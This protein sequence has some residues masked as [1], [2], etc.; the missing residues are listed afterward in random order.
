VHTIILRHKDELALSWT[1]CYDELHN[2][3]FSLVTNRM[4]KSREVIW[5][6]HVTRMGEKEFI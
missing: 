4:I 3:Y 5:V 6:R 1:K 2:L